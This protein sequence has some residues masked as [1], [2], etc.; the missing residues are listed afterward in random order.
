MIRTRFA[1]SPTGDLHI[2]GARTALFNFLFARGAG[3]DGRFVLRVDDTDAER[4][5]VEYERHLMEDLLWLGLDWDEGPDRGL[6]VSYR[7]SERARFYDGALSVLRER[8]AVYPCFCSGERLEALRREQ[9]A[10]GDPPR[11][12]GACR[13]LSEDGVAQRLA[14]GE[15]PC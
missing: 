12:D 8:G 14:A 6:A 9:L 13:G 2:G 5:R 11:Y 10:K 7:Q 15:K 1:P 4:S 3:A